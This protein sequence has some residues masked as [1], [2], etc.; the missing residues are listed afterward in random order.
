MGLIFKAGYTVD[1]EIN[2][3]KAVQNDFAIKESPQMKMQVVDNIDSSSVK[4]FMTQ[5]YFCRP[6]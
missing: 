1:F 3:Y 2:F 4:L 5:K 6:L